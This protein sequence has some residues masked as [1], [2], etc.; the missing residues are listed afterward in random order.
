[1]SRRLLLFALVT[2]TVLGAEALEPQGAD[3]RDAVVAVGVAPA[4]GYLLA[5]YDYPGNDLVALGATAAG[6]KAGEMVVAS[7]LRGI[8]WGT[9][10]GRLFGGL[11]IVAGVV[12]G[13]L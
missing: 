12:L 7:V 4:G 1:M 6:G 8:R 2:S 5:T 9:N 13:A 10:T 11:G 3:S